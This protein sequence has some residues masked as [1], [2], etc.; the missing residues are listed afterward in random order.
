[1]ISTEII[2]L[3]KWWQKALL[4]D[5]AFKIHEMNALEMIGRA[6]PETPSIYGTG[7]D[8][9]PLVRWKVEV[10]VVS[11][12]QPG[13]PVINLISARGLT[14][15]LLLLLFLRS[16]LQHFGREQSP[17]DCIY[18]WRRTGTSTKHNFSDW[19]QLNTKITDGVPSPVP[20]SS[21]GGRKL[22]ARWASA[23]W[24]DGRSYWWPEQAWCSPATPDAAQPGSAHN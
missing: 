15:F 22:P 8:H 7:K 14:F 11:L 6:S 13:T 21:A 23:P 2:K 1:M 24:W 3:F 17:C 4:Q 12:L 18:L 9:V 5:R 20:G 16:L 10:G 19:R